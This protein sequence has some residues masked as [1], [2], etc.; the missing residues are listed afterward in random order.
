L[1]PSGA[2]LR[3]SV[4]RPPC[5]K[6]LCLR[7]R[8]HGAKL[9]PGCRKTQGPLLTARTCDTQAL[10]DRRLTP[11]LTAPVDRRPLPVH[12]RPSTGAVRSASPA[13]VGT[14]VTFPHYMTRLESLRSVALRGAVMFGRN[15]PVWLQA[16]GGKALALHSHARR[17]GCSLGGACRVAY[18]TEG[19]HA[20]QPMLI[21]SRRP[22]PR[23]SRVGESLP[24][25]GSKSCS[26]RGRYRFC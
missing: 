22:L 2:Q 7:G 12:L 6:S 19:R 4:G 24:G 21:G 26:R 1:R 14:A 25:H 8:H 18:L 11:S 5:G 20:E 9:E 16:A 13:L 23:S 15:S 3:S 10:A 17:D